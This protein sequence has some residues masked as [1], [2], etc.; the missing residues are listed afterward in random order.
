MAVFFTEDAAQVVA[1]SMRAGVAVIADD[2]RL[3]NDR[4]LLHA[5]PGTDGSTGDVGYLCIMGIARSPQE[6]D[7]F[8]SERAHAAGSL[9]PPLEVFYE[10]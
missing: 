3:E 1:V 7:V 5:G 8:T 2:G 6:H 10:G 4:E 9:H